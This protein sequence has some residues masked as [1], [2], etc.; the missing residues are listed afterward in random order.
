MSDR[1]PGRPRIRE[2]LRIRRMPGFETAPPAPADARSEDDP[3]RRA[4]L[5][6]LVRVLATELP[7]ADAARLDTLLGDALQSVGEAI[8]VEHAYLFRRLG[9]PP[10]LV[11]THEW[12]DESGRPSLKDPGELMAEVLEGSTRPQPHEPILLEDSAPRPGGNLTH[13]LLVALGARSL[14]AMPLVSG[15]ST[16]GVAGFATERRERA[17][18]PDSWRCCASWATCSS[19]RSSATSRA[20]RSRSRIAPW[21][22]KR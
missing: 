15:A 9:Q 6:Q 14:V 8:E 17:F 1:L 12:C 20:P 5:E 3:A 2:T 16:L 19:R 13:P 22:A 4:R 10:R 18:S 7:G 11:L 21:S